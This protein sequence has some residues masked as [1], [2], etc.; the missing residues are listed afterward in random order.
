MAPKVKSL[1]RHV[2]QATVSKRARSETRSR[3]VHLPPVSV[4]R[5]WARRT[6]AVNGALLEAA[7]E[8]LRRKKGLLVADPFA[9][10]G[11]IPL[12]ALKRGYSV[13]AQDLNPWVAQ[14]LS[15]MLGLPSQA[16]LREATDR[17]LDLCEPLATKA[18]GTLFSDG[19]PAQLAHAIR[20][21]VACCSRCGHAHRLF[22]H[23]LVSRTKRKERGGSEAML[24]CRRGHLFL[25]DAA[26]NSACPECTRNVDPAGIYLADRIATCPLCAHQESLEARAHSGTWRWELVLVERSNGARRELAIPTYDEQHQAI[27]DAWCP[28]RRLGAIPEAPETRVLRRHGFTSWSDIYPQ[29]QRYVMEELLKL[30]RS[31]NLSNG[32]QSGP[33]IGMEKG[34]LTGLGTGLS[35]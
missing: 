31:S 10:G 23:A 11:V 28:R 29:R 24:A 26:V 30:T 5:W 25:G 17:L 2:D 1:L 9:G 32:K 4:Y 33:R 3:E 34:P 14:G 18:Y 19:T 6:E 12:S 16:R 7:A 13:Y 27:D 15:V 21:A 20:V 22:P 35:R 8:E